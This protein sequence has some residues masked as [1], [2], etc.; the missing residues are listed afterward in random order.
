VL[1]S[2]VLETVHDLEQVEVQYEVLPGWQ[3]DISNVPHLGGPAEAAQEYV[4]RVQELVGGADQVDRCWCRTRR[5]RGQTLS[6]EG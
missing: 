6:N 2:S 3:R 4:V 5:A 1:G